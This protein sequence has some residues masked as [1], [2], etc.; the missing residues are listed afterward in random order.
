MTSHQDMKYV[1]LLGFYEYLTLGADFGRTHEKNQDWNEAYDQ[2]RN[3]A[4]A[5]LRRREED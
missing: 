3:E 2:G 4:E 1:K 5:Y